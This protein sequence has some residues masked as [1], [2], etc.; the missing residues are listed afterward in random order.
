M[1]VGQI[2]RNFNARYKDKIYILHKKDNSKYA[3]HILVTQYEY[4]TT[5]DA[6]DLLKM[7]PKLNQYLTFIHSGWSGTDLQMTKKCSHFYM[8]Q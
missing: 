5:D 1:Y 2:G 7:T 3:K 4:R 8:L 6:L